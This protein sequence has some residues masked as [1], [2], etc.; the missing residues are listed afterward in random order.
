M[1]TGR[2]SSRAAISF[3]SVALPPLALQTITSIA[4]ICK[5]CRSAARLN[6]PRPSTTSWKRNGNGSRGGS[7]RR[8]TNRT[9]V[10]D[11]KMPTALA[12]T[13]SQAR[14]P[15]RPTSCAA[16]SK[17]STSI[18]RSSGCGRQGGRSSISRGT[19]ARSAAKRPAREISAAKGWVASISRSTPCSIM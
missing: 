16:A 7:I 2:L 6:G 8:T 14:R 18:Q 17:L 10:A 12:P 15:M 4:C 3:A 13:V 19:P 9:D 11:A 5:R 1:M